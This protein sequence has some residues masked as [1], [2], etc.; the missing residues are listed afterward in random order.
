MIIHS[1]ESLKA[2]AVFQSFDEVFVTV[3]MGGLTPSTTTSRSRAGKLTRITGTYLPL[4]SQNMSGARLRGNGK[5][6]FECLCFPT[7][8]GKVDVSRFDAAPLKAFIA[9]KESDYG[10]ET[11]G[12]VPG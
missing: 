8:M 4:V 9:A 11:N 5:E 2:V 10:T 1:D 3:S 6:R 7:H 12:R